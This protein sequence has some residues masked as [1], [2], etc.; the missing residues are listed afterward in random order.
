L[1]EVH[2]S[3]EFVA[4]KDRLLPVVRFA[5]EQRLVDRD[6]D[7]WD[8]ATLLEIAVLVRDWKDARRHLASALTRVREFW[9]P[10]T[11]SR[12]LGLLEDLRRL[13]KED[14][15]DLAELRAALESKVK[16]LKSG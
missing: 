2:G 9:E 13:R 16:Q 8:H 11:T 1:L 14:V 6:G 7:Y 12:N 5:A 10:E 4:R 3:P 15:T